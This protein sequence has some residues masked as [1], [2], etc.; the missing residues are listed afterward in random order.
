MQ[1]LSGKLTRG[2]NE[3]QYKVFTP[4]GTADFDEN[5]LAINGAYPGISPGTWTVRG[6]DTL[7]SIA[8][9]LWG[10]A[11]L[12][13]ILA[14]ANGLQGTDVL[15][16][17]QT[18]TVP[19]KVTN[20]HNTATT[21]KPYDPGRA[22]GNTQPTLPDPPP[23]PGRGG[24]C[25][26]FLTVIAIV[27]AVVVTVYTA[28]AA[29]AA[30]GGAASA[31][32]GTGAAAGGAAAG[33]AAAGGAVAGGAVAGGAVAGGAVAGGAAAATAST[34]SLGIAALS[35][36]GTLMTAGV[37]V[38]ASAIGGAVGSLASQ[39]VLIAGGAQQGLDLKGVA[40]SAGS[41]A[42][43]A[44]MGGTVSA[45]LGNTG[46]AMATGALRGAA[47][48]G[49]SIA[50]GAQNGFD[51]KGIAASAIA[52]GA[53]AYVGDALGQT[54]LGKALPSLS[55]GASALAS[56]VTSTLVRGGSLQR[57]AGAIA[58]DTIGAMVIAQMAAKSVTPA[59]V[60]MDEPTNADSSS[61]PLGEAKAFHA[62]FDEPMPGVMYASNS[63]MSD[64]DNP[65]PYV[66]YSQ[67]EAEGLPA[68]E[69]TA[70]RMPFELSLS[71]ETYAFGVG[72]GG[73]LAGVTETATVDLSAAAFR[74]AMT[75]EKDTVDLSGI[76]TTLQAFER[77]M[78][79]GYA[80]VLDPSPRAAYTG[81][82]AHDAWRDLKQLGYQMIGGQ[83]AD[84]ARAAWNS[85]SYG[86]AAAKELQ[87]FGEAGLAL[88]GSG[89]ART[90]MPRA[91][92]S[93]ASR[94][95]MD[96]VRQSGGTIGSRFPRTEGL[97]TH[98]TL[99]ELRATGALPG[100]EGVI[101]IDRTVRFGDVY[102][103]GTLGGRQ[104]EFSLV[105]ERVDGALVKK[106]YSGDAWTSPVPRDARLIGHVHP[107]DNA[108]K[109]W[110]STQ[111]MEMVNIR[112]FRQLELN[113]QANPTP[114]RIFWGP[115]NV[116]STVFY[117][118]FGKAPLPR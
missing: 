18:L 110:P 62:Q 10:D 6:G 68:V 31:G 101:V 90:A 66:T 104:V 105:T 61:T 99:D 7:Q 118:G 97:G 64:V 96:L 73:A 91:T 24:G 3:S 100:K 71:D 65:Y 113:P 86:L 41:A 37:A 4:V 63:L 11:T 21:F 35:G 14:D 60:K 87:A 5:Y 49:M 59:K 108:F 38:G 44:S 23:P 1:E 72:Y 85:G 69:V 42:L 84:E 83:S 8:S 95:S 30:I 13:Y 55:L 107:N 39:A 115:G 102:E 19:S 45:G 67:G 74:A 94:T 58:G 27:V 116:D 112:Y 17:G 75:S 25:G 53:S 106:L 56:G 43:G 36:G 79:G 26:A 70:S 81:A 12:W 88:M 9:A 20:V 57:N 93:L 22:I 52:S 78:T 51:W 114:T 117:P 77:G 32:A 89:V 34:W 28:G 98:T 111:D 29:S 40:I 33:G 80:G 109:V 47:T 76:E 82:L 15:K 54:K 2:G 48:Q 46:N 92:V 103:L 16:A 50:L